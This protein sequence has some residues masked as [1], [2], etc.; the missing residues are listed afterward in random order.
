MKIFKIKIEL[1]SGF[2]KIV[3]QRANH[4]HGAIRQIYQNNPYLLRIVRILEE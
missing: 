1:Q 3:Y 4:L 2:T